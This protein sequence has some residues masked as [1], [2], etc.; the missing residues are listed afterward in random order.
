MYHIRT[1]YSILELGGLYCGFNVAFNVCANRNTNNY[2]ASNSA[3]YC[4][5]NVTLNKSNFVGLLSLYCQPHT[6]WSAPLH[7]VGVVVLN[8]YNSLFI[9]YCID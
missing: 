5:S 2:I 9:G 1:R 3:A 6:R 8:E 7:P 4:N